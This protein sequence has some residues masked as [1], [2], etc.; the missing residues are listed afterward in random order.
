MFFAT[1]VQFDP[2]SAHFWCR[3]YQNFLA[4]MGAGLTILSLAGCWR[5]LDESLI[6]VRI[7][8]VSNS[9]NVVEL[10]LMQARASAVTVLVV[11]GSVGL[12]A[13]LSAWAS[14]GISTLLLIFGLSLLFAGIVVQALVNKWKFEPLRY[15][16]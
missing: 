6:N 7:A 5:W 10:N 11:S 2:A 9:R 1:K 4:L 15:K 13:L 12:W 3:I 14:S 8:R 16:D